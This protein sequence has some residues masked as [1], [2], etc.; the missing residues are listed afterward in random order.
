[1]LRFSYSLKKKLIATKFKYLPLTNISLH[2]SSYTRFTYGVFSRKTMVQINGLILVV[3]LMY[4]Q[5]TQLMWNNCIC[6]NYSMYSFR[7]M[8]YAQ[9]IQQKRL[10]H[11]RT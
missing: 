4:L 5:S 9:N 10:I 11:K 8:I 3:N 2:L 1:M 6:G 7:K